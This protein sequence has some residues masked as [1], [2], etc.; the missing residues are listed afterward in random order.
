MLPIGIDIFECIITI[1]FSS[2]KFLHNRSQVVP[3][4]LLFARRPRHIV[5]AVLGGIAEHALHRQF[6]PVLLE[7]SGPYTALRLLGFLVALSDL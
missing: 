6:V 7:G 2:L 1:T 4:C 3:V 5:V